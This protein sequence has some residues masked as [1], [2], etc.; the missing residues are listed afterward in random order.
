MSLTDEQVREGHR[1]LETIADEVAT[2]LEWTAAYREAVVASAR[3]LIA[4]GDPT[5]RLQAP[6]RH[7]DVRDLAHAAMIELL[8]P[9]YFTPF[10]DPD[11]QLAL[12]L[13][14]AEWSADEVVKRLNFYDNHN[15]HVP[16]LAWW[17]EGCLSD[18]A[19][20]A[21]LLD[22]WIMTPTRQVPQWEWVQLFKTAGFLSDASAVQRPSGPITLWRGSTSRGWRR[23]AW[24]AHQ[25]TAEW[26]A[27][28]IP[29][30][31][32]ADVGV[33]FEA[34]VKAEHVFAITD[35]RGESEY[36]VNP[37]SLCTSRNVCHLRSYD[38]DD[39]MPDKN[40]GREVRYQAPQVTP[41]S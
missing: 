40:A 2:P 6:A 12:T 31:G 33:L 35:D 32:V 1:L 15:R 29:Y 10:R 8:H 38:R 36:I 22:V 26:F 37:A 13:E 7:E 39:P 30:I 3:P 25:P 5:P 28:R 27:W 34:T 4:E 23:L 17:N 18:K 21:T 24:T 9:G 11:G 19:L 16:F 20:R 41:R 14:D